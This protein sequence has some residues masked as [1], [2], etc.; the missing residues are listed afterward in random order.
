MVQKEMCYKLP[1]H[2]E[3]LS[4]FLPIRMGEGKQ[5]IID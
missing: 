5:M 1:L 3:S 4:L 2:F